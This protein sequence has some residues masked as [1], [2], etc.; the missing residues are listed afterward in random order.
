MKKRRILIPLLA[1]FMAAPAVQ[2]DDGLWIEQKSGGRQGFTFEQQP[3]LSYDGD[4][5]VVKAGD[6][7]ASFP[8]ENVARVYFADD[9]TPTTN[10]IEALPAGTNGQLIRVGKAQADLYGYAPGTAVSVYDTAG[11]QLSTLKADAQ[12][13]A[14]VT[15]TALPQGTYIIKANQ[16]TLKIKK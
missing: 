11:R 9:V 5:L 2:A 13:R 3:V 7:E 12:G 16:S 4:A 8:L 14:T 15:L 1:L 10:A 6:V